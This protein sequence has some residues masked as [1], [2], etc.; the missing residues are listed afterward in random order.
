MWHNSCAL[1]YIIRYILH[2]DVI[3]LNIFCL[4]GPLC[5][6]L[7]RHRWIT[8][9]K[10]S[11]A[12]LCLN[13]RLSKQ[14]RRR[15]LETPSR[16]LWRHCNERLFSLACWK[17]AMPVRYDAE[18]V[19]FDRFCWALC[20]GCLC[21]M[22]VGTDIDKK[23]TIPNFSLFLL[24]VLFLGKL[25]LSCPYI[26]IKQHVTM[27]SPFLASGN[28]RSPKYSPHNTYLILMWSRKICWT[29]SK[30]V[31]GVRHKDSGTV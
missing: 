21:D 5:G 9:T 31:G 13:K 23:N 8:L 27:L 6:K 18:V 20:H 16:S 26:I 3:K 12:E 19:A 1:V 2:D 22:I 28:H 24:S 30:V 7:T 25:E 14:S 11:E 10:A 15:W 4:T 17:A 29:N